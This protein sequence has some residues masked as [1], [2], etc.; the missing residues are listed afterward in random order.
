MEILELPGFF[1]FFFSISI[2]L[3]LLFSTG[4]GS[5]FIIGRRAKK[6][7]RARG[8]RPVHIGPFPRVESDM[9]EISRDVS[10]R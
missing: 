9:M 6:G 4:I 1:S 3:L 2:F 7:S 10:M 5:V 8:F